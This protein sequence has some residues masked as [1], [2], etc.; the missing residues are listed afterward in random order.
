MKNCLAVMWFF[1]GI[2]VL[3]CTR[4][5]YDVASSPEGSELQFQFDFSGA[6]TKPEEIPANE[7]VLMSGLVSDTRYCFNAETGFSISK[8][9]EF[10]VHNGEYFITS[11][12]SLNDDYSIYDIG[13]FVR[14]ENPM[15]VSN[16]ELC[17]KCMTDEQVEETYCPGLKSIANS[18]VTVTPATPFYLSVDKR[19]PVYFRELGEK[20]VLTLKP[21]ESYVSLDFSVM[22]NLEEGVVVDSMFAAISGVP[23]RMNILEKTT[24]K[25]ALGK[26]FF[27]MFP[28]SGNY[29]SGKYV[30]SV[31]TLG[32][33]SADFG[34]YITG[35][36]IF[37]VI[38]IASCEGTTRAIRAGLNIKEIIDNAGLMKSSDD[39]QTWALAVRKAAIPI[40]KTLHISREM[41]LSAGEDGAEGWI[42]VRDA[43]DPIIVE[44]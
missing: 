38:V 10:P 30:G 16:L 17:V 14:T 29:I 8:E 20:I 32:L 7:T 3:S 1:V 9:T 2:L 35:P 26:T 37:W 27:R 34:D 4:V 24:V 28:E 36:G 19:V 23:Y 41:I 33:F 31:N 39:G 15:P 21:V 12:A 11:V 40:Q 44:I 5:D 22:L 25:D 42:P 43:E 13:A 6:G 18:F